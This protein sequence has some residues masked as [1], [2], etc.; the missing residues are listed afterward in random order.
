MVEK[1]AFIRRGRALTPG[2]RAE[3]SIFDIGTGASSV[4]FTADEVIEAPNWTPDGKHLFFNAGGQIWRIDTAGQQVPQLIDTS[5]LA[6]LNNDHLISPDGS[7]LYLSSDDGH[8]Y[9]VSITGGTPRRISN[10][11]DTP[12]H[13][14]L[15]G[16]SPDGAELAYVAVEGGPDKRR[17][18]LFTIPAN[19]GADTRLSDIDKPNDGPD[20]SP[21]GL[22]IYFNSERASGLPGHAQ[23]FRMERDGTHIEQLTDDERVNWFPH[24]A[25]DGKS[26][27]YISYPVAT[28][29]HPADK[30]VII[31]MLSPEGGKPRDLVHLFGGQGTINVNSWAPDSRRF[32]YVAYPK[33]N[34]R[35]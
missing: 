16:I 8:L 7:T 32:A 24:P 34:A 12:F 17:I 25:P 11:H 33:E 10:R 35:R 2:Q 31:R 5:D 9:A 23:I 20:Y 14:Y 1:L 19:G 28:L 30:D 21:G 6:D 27:V 18:N 15:H 4:I 22:W 26:V 3:L 13:Y 29:G